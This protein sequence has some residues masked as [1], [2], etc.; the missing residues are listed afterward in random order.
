L[1]LG[2]DP[3]PGEYN[4]ARPQKGKNKKTTPSHWGV[5]GNP[6]MLQKAV[7]LIKKYSSYRKG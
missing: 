4:S 1:L 5:E 7:E 6:K 3:I 2:T